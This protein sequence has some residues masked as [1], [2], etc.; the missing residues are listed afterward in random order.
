MKYIMKPSILW[1][2]FP[3]FII[4]ALMIIYLLLI[5]MEKQ[6]LNIKKGRRTV[7]PSPLSLVG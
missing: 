1:S 3:V 5:L 7:T 6:I 2:F 4:L